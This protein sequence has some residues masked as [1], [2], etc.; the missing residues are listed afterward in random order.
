M[1][2]AELRPSDF[3]EF[4]GQARLKETLITHCRS[5]CERKK[6][7]EHILLTGPPGSGKSS[8]G[9][10]IANQTGDEF[11][12]VIMPIKPRVMAAVMRNFH[13]ILF[14]DEIHRCSNRE[15]EMLLSVLE[16]GYL[17]L[18]TGKRIENGWLTIVA[19]TTDPQ[20]LLPALTERFPIR[21]F[22]EEYTPE[23]LADIGSRMADVLSVPLDETI[24]QGL[25]QAAGGVPRNMRTLVL[26]ARDLWVVQ[27]T[28]P[29]L[30]EILAFR[31]VTLDG[32]TREHQQYL[33]VLGDLSGRAGLSTLSSVLRLHP[34]HIQE[35]ERLL[36]SRQYVTISER[37]R[38]LSY[39]GIVIV[40]ADKLTKPYRR[41]PPS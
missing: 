23:N 15:Q 20:K 31:G 14:C 26:A 13:G 41:K 16:D 11:Y 2:D 28:M 10:L 32:L 17:Q 1:N 24:L 25:G 33:K 30:D 5:A 38:E 40:D 36:L 18:D 34:N 39:E 9:I 22:F 27:D 12:S 35:L 8:L 4:I 3:D 29:T 7:L 21:P 37:G 19:A 6:P